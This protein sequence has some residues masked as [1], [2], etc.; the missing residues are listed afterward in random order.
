MKKETRLKNGSLVAVALVVTLAMAPT[1][2]LAVDNQGTGDI[3]GDGAALTDSNVFQL[4]STG[5]TLA[6]V[7]RAFQ[8]DGTPI[9]D[10]S[11]LPSSTP[12]KFVIY[13]NNN[14]SIAMN[15]VSVRDV[16]DAAFTYQAGTIKVDNT[17]VDCGA[18]CDAAEEATIFTNVDGGTVITDGV[19][20]DVASIAGATIDAGDANVAN[21]TL[22]IAANR[23]WA[24]LF[25]VTIS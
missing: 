14:A 7:K 2:A 17:T 8:S 23:V 5:S 24:I 6:L 15:D 22:N 12:V 3:A 13:V 19:D 10:G 1:T 9:P 18:S 4:F 16:L 21:G 11:T 20:G 25:E